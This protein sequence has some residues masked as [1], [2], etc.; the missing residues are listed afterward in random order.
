MNDEDKQ[1]PGSFLDGFWRGVGIG[2]KALGLF[3]IRIVLVAASLTVLLSFFSFY[4]RL[5]M[6]GLAVPLVV[7]V[8]IF[9]IPQ[10]KSD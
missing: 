1:K 4:E 3:T 7:A 10:K 5:G 6:W 8:W 9:S 2:E